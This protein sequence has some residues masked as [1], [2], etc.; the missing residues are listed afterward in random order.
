MSV[1]AELLIAYFRLTRE[2]RTWNDLRELEREIR[3]SRRP[4]NAK[5]PRRLRRRY[6][7]AQSDVDGFP[8]HTVHRRTGGAGPHVLHPPEVEDPRVSPLFGSLDGLAPMAVFIGTRDVLLPDARR[9]R[10]DAAAA[11]VPLDYREYPGMVHNWPMR[12]L[13]EGRRA[14]D[15]IAELIRSH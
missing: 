1:R 6:H 12:R 14:L 13:P 8:C 11:G 10:K 3:R 7:V 15:Q 5:L 9:L 4:S 2:K